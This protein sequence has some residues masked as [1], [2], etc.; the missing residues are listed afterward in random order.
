MNQKTVREQIDKLAGALETMEKGFAEGRI[1]PEG[2]KDFK[3]AVDN[4][5]TTV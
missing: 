3:A 5:R 2:L 4:A 1:P